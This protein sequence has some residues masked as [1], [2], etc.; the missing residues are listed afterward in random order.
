LTAELSRIHLTVSR[1]LLEKLDAARA[2]LSHSHPGASRDEILEVGLDLI[3][4]RQAKRRGLVKNPRKKAD[5]RSATLPTATPTSSPQ[6]RSR[7]ISADVRRAVWERD[8]GK[9]Q[10]RLDSGEICGSDRQLE[11]HHTDP[12]ALGGE[13]TIEKLGIRCRPHND[14][15]A[16]RVF[17]DEAMNRFTGR[18]PTAREPVGLWAA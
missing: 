1:R 7:Y 16:R 10:F 6:S 5:P 17:G 12:F 15:E 18:P 2:A 9:C 3:L 11:I 8:Q 14:V 13:S 4:E